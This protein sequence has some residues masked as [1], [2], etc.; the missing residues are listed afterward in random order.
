MAQSVEQLKTPEH[1]MMDLPWS[2]ADAKF[3]KIK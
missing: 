1:S 2:I 3:N